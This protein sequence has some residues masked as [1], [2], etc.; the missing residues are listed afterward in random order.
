MHLNFSC[1]FMVQ[2]IRLHSRSICT[3]FMVVIG[4]PYIL[5]D[6]GS[7]HDR[8]VPM[9]MYVKQPLHYMDGIFM[10]LR[11]FTKLFIYAHVQN[12][13]IMAM[14]AFVWLGIG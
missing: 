5:V 3:Y 7:L 1:T 4:E 10:R 13:K 9:Y 12:Q 14:C 2:T 11:L 8:L 6:I